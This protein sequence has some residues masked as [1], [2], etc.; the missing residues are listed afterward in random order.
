MSVFTDEERKYLSEPKL[1]RLATVGPMA[2]HM[3]SQSGSGTTPRWTPSTSVASASTGPRSSVISRPT[4]SSRSWSTMS[5]P[6]ASQVGRDPGPRTGFG[7]GGRR[8]D[9]GHAHQDHLAGTRW[10]AAHPQPTGRRVIKSGPAQ[11]GKLR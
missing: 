9:P 6:P 5:C 10:D 3:S 7:S 1:G 4:P 2:S 8:T 11:R